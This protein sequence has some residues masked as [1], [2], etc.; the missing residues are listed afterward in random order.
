MT[1]KGH[2]KSNQGYCRTPGNLLY[3]PHPSVQALDAPF[4]ILSPP[5][6]LL[7]NDVLSSAQI[8]I[9]INV[10]TWVTIIRMRIRSCSRRDLSLENVHFILSYPSFLKKFKSP[11]YL[12][13]IITIFI[14]M[15]RRVG[16]S[17]PREKQSKVI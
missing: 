6:R 2:T 4:P 16:A 3:Q 12:L 13:N 17:P 9:W 11:G 1:F 14:L 5:I 8:E 10:S 15:P 7:V